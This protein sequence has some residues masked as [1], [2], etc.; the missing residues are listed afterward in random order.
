MDPTGIARRIVTFAGVAS[1]L[2][3]GAASAAPASTDEPAL[4]RLVRDALAGAAPGTVTVD[5]VFRRI[6]L[7][8][9]DRSVLTR[10]PPNEQAVAVDTR[11]HIAA[12]TEGTRTT[13]N[14]DLAAGR[15]SVV[16]IHNHP[17]GRGLSPADIAQLTDPSVLGVI[18]VG[19]DRSVYAA[20]LGRG[21]E[22]VSYPTFMRFVSAAGADTRRRIS[23]ELS[24]AGEVYESHL[25]HMV[26]SAL[27]QAGMIRYQSVLGDLRRKSFDLFGNVFDRIIEGVVREM[28]ADLKRARARH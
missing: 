23:G 6:R 7:A 22:G 24:L 3:A 20:S 5:E 9:R 19:H 12:A 27:G 10:L 11:G 28:K 21:F 26:S 16:L 13:V 14:V 17:G 4:A 1:L 8:L 18:A 25:E 15:D 2:L